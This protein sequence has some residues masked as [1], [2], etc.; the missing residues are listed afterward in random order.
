MLRVYVRHIYLYIRGVQANGRVY[1]GQR[2][3][4]PASQ[5]HVVD[6]HMA[7]SVER[8]VEVNDFLGSHRSVKSQEKHNL[9]RK[10]SANSIIA[11]ENVRTFC[12]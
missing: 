8:D 5:N 7:I 3:H 10:Q 6:N 2:L 11:Q 9:V 1:Q 12:E 4:P